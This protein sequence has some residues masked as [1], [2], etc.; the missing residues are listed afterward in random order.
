MNDTTEHGHS[1]GSL[2]VI[3]FVWSSLLVLTF[4]ETV[5]AYQHLELKVMLMVL[6]TLSIVKASLI[7]AYFMHLRYERLSLVLTLM[8][9]MVFVI[10]MMFMSFPDSLRLTLMRMP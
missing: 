9:A 6:M 5:L 4:V 1:E 3:F 10:A 8:P 2:R 7:I